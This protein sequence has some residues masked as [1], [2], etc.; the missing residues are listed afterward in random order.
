MRVSPEFLVFWYGHKLALKHCD[1]GNLRGWLPCSAV[2]STVCSPGCPNLPVQRLA[3]ALIQPPVPAHDRV[4]TESGPLRKLQPGELEAGC[5]HCLE[6]SAI[7][8]NLRPCE[9]LASEPAYLLTWCFPVALLLG[10]PTP[11]DPRPHVPNPFSLSS[12]SASH[13]LLPVTQPVL[14]QPLCVHTLPLPA[15]LECHLLACWSSCGACTFT[16]GSCPGRGFQP[17]E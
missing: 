15:S 3:R 14:L 13:P 1:C 16:E 17:Q 5:E 4:R 12:V 11:R 6:L 8:S 7:R 10:L 9:Q 2:N